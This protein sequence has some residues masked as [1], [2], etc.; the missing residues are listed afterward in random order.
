MIDRAGLIARP[1]RRSSCS[2]AADLC[3]G[4]QVLV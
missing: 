1:L 2:G 3:R 4:C